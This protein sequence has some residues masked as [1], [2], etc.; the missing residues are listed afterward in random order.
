MSTIYS[1]VAMT[2][3]LLLTSLIVKSGV[4]NYQQK[5]NSNLRERW[6]SCPI[7]SSSSPSPESISCPPIPSCPIYE[8]CPETKCPECPSPTCPPCPATTCPPPV[9]S[10]PCE[11]REAVFLSKFTA[12]GPGLFTA[13]VPIGIKSWISYSFLSG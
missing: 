2:L 8:S 7:C 9:P 13:K 5:E 6:P 11:S 3:I 10:T 12:A 4:H 1:V